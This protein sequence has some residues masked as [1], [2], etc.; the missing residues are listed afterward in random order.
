MKLHNKA[1]FWTGIAMMFI[2]IIGC[3]IIAITF[4]DWSWLT[5]QLLLVV[6]SI[7]ACSFWMILATIL[8]WNGSVTP[9]E[10]LKNKKVK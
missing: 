8:I 2:P 7:L 1:R 10:N 3:G 6:F 4:L 5:E 9:K